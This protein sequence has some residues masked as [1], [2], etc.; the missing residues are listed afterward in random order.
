M[1]RVGVGLADT[2]RLISGRIKTYE[3]GQGRGEGPVAGRFALIGMSARYSPSN[4]R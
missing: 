4:F 1:T 3:A 2:R